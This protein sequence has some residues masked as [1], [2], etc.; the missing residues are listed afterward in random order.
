ML[1]K[2]VKFATSFSHGPISIAG[3]SET[4][5]LD[6]HA[7]PGVAAQ[8]RLTR[9]CAVLVTGVDGDKHAKIRIGLGSQT[10]QCDREFLLSSIDGHTDGHQRT[11]QCLLPSRMRPA[12]ISAKYGAIVSLPG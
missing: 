8:E 1:L 6:P 9:S 4:R 12:Q 7:E 2:N 5:W 3:P 10:L 11:I